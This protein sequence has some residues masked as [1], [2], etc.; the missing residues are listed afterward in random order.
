MICQH[1]QEIGIQ[2]VKFENFI[3]KTTHFCCQLLIA[4]GFMTPFAS[5]LSFVL[6]ISTASSQ[7]TF[8][9]LLIS[10]H[11][12]FFKLSVMIY[13]LKNTITIVRSVG[14][15]L[16]TFHFSLH[17]LKIIV[18]FFYWCLLIFIL[19]VCMGVCLSVSVHENMPQ[20]IM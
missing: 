18:Y 1:Y 8:I 6:K 13:V 19:V 2:K 12:L 4:L 20:H 5:G 7:L 16:S 14:G 17:L 10:F 15:H 9:S 3:R 11:S